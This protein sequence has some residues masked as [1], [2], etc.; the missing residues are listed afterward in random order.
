MGCLLCT[1]LQHHNRPCQLQPSMEIVLPTFCIRHCCQAQQMCLQWY[2]AFSSTLATAGRYLCRF[3][4]LTPI[5]PPTPKSVSVW[6]LPF[7]HAPTVF[8]ISSLVLSLASYSVP[9]LCISPLS[10]ALNLNSQS[11][12]HRPSF[13]SVSFFC[14]S[15][16]LPCCA[17]PVATVTDYRAGCCNE[18][19]LTL[20]VCHGGCS[21]TPLLNGYR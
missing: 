12:S 2:C 8:F 15:Q 10:A 21:S 6:C 14:F 19:V 9:L 4:G 7:T 1:L 16:M 20:H 3:K 17:R 11:F 5:Y 13:F 18:R